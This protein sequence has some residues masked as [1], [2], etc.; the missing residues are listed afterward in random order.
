MLKSSFR[1]SGSK[2]NISIMKS[3]SDH[4]CKW[5][6]ICDHYNLSNLDI[7]INFLKNIIFCVDF[8]WKLASKNSVKEIPKEIGKE[9]E[10]SKFFH[11]IPF[12]DLDA[13]WYDDRCWKP[14]P[15]SILNIFNNSLAIFDDLSPFFDK[16]WASC[17]FC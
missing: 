5:F 12:F 13:F 4:Q 8:S 3:V 1:C 6:L 17:N 2:I 16:V 9:N 11:R 14:S 7:E 15:G 10:F